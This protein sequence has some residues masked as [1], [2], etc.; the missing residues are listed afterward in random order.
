LLRAS[1]LGALIGVDLYLKVEGN[2]PTGSFKDR[3]MVVAVAG[4]LARGAKL[5]LCASTG[6]TAASAAA[7]AARAGLSCIVVLPDGAVA[8]GKIAQALVH[9]AQLITVRGGFDTA[10]ELAAGAA[11]SCGGV[12][13]NSL[14][15]LRLEGQKTAAFEVVTALGGAPDYLVLPVGNAGNISAY[16][17]GFCEYQE[18]G[19][20]ER[21][22]RMVG[23]QAVG[24]DPLV[25]GNPI[26]HPT[27]LA[28]AIRIGRPASWASAVAAREESGGRFFAVS[29]S[30]ITAARDWLAATEGVFAE[31]AS[32]AACA[33]LMQLVPAGGIA[34][35][36]TVVVVLTGHGLKDPGA[37]LASVR[38]P[39]PVDARLESLQEAI[40]WP[41][42]GPRPREVAGVGGPLV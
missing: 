6:N 41:Q 25:R 39:E 15:P 37:V 11:E 30:Q 31:P 33:G 3:G 42:S 28:S 35:G 18:L 16:W 38:V 8:T 20:I 21:C 10:L 40:A 29:D 17:R 13:V 26:A 19:R 24:A 27:T 12:L 4:A 23:V 32:A 22:P 2:N 5:L 14:N 34:R 1:R 9:G 36:S 7:Y